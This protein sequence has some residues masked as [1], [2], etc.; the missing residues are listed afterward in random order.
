VPQGED[1]Y[2]TGIVVDDF[3]KALAQLAAQAGHRFAEP[4]KSSLRLRTPAGESTVDL[5]VTYSCG[6]GPLIEVIQAVP[7]T[8]WQPVAGSGLHHLGYWVDDIGAESAALIAAG[9]PLEAAGL[10]PDDQVVYAYH[11][12]EHSVRIEL[13][14]RAMKPF[15]DAWISGGQHP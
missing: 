8:H 13:V 10:G 15:I 3:D 1:L 4:M 2:H 11:Y 14:D 5:L 6:P 9:M 12:D 7:G